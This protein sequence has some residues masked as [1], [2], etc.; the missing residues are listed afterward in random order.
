MNKNNLDL[1]F[2]YQEPLVRDYDV[3]GID[4]E[5]RAWD[6]KHEKGEEKF[7]NFVKK[8]SLKDFIHTYIRVF[9]DK[10]PNGSRLAFSFCG[11]VSYPE[12]NIKE[13]KEFDRSDIKS[14]VTE[15][16]IG[17]IKNE[18]DP[19]N[20]DVYETKI[21]I[22]FKKVFSLETVDKALEG[23]SY[24]KNRENDITVYEVEDSPIKTLEVTD[25]SFSI[26]INEDKVV[27]YYKL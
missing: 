21:N 6:K 9:K 10:F 17:P 18:F 25:T 13:F 5:Q 24:T 19:G 8:C 12:E 26:N 3:M 27:L 16:Y 15:K 2:L 1:K 22:E 23:L 11:N 4:L 14:Y 20:R 7:R